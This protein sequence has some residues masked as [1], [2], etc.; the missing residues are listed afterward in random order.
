[1]S[2]TEAEA[3]AAIARLEASG[4]LQPVSRAERPQ[5]KPKRTRRTLGA[6]AAT[7]SQGSALEQQF[8]ALL[9][10]EAPDLVYQREYKFAQPWRQFRFDFVFLDR[11]VAVE[12]DG[13]QHLV[14]GGRHNTDEDRTKL[15][16]AAA[17]G[18]RVIRLSGSMLTAE[19]VALLRRALER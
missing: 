5:D 8:I 16:M 14:N 15:N 19:S 12:I 11:L 6:D 10:S 3:E 17:L 1:M 18:W 2:W 13:G 7:A 4:V 9:A